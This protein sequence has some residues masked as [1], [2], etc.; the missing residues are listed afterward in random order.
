MYA[1]AL[2]H[3][4]S[5]QLASLTADRPQVMVTRLQGLVATPQTSSQFKYQANASFVVAYANIIVR[6]LVVF[7]MTLNPL[8]LCGRTVKTSAPL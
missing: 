7:D 5:N 2:L 4:T 8:A 3:E 1:D 6:L